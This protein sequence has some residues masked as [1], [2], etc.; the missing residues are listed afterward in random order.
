MTHESLIR[1][2]ILCIITATLFLFAGIGLAQTVQA[3]PDPMTA[4][5]CLIGVGI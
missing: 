3:A 1:Y 4:T 2:I 5:I